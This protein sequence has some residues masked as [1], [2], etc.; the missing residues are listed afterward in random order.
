[1]S[2][3]AFGPDGPLAP[4]PGTDPVIQ[5]MS[6]VMSLTGEHDG[7]PVLVG[8]PMADFTGAMTLT[9]AVLLGLM[10]RDRTGEGPHMD[11]SML[12]AMVYSL[13]TRLASYW[14]N[15]EEPER[16]GSAHSVVAP[17]QAYETA[18]GYVVAGAWAPEAWPRFCRA[19]DR[20]DLV[21]DPRFATNP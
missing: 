8:V 6:G 14:A 7:G 11:V 3:S 21:E 20:S 16:W 13:T 4:Y 18:D 15:G 19:I 1:C 12:A 5:A 2:V 9:Q 17:Y 10:A